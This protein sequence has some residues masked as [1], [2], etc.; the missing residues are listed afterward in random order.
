MLHPQVVT[1]PRRLA[2]T[3][4]VH[5]SGDAWN[6][7]PTRVTE[8]QRNCPRSYPRR[9]QRGGTLTR[10]ISDPGRS[11]P[12]ES[13]VGPSDLTSSYPC[14]L[15]ARELLELTGPR[16]ALPQVLL[17]VPTHG[18]G[19]RRRHWTWTHDGPL[20]GC[21]QPRKCGRHPVGVRPVFQVHGRWHVVG[22]A[23]GAIQSPLA[24]LME[25]THTDLRIP[26]DGRPRRGSARLSTRQVGKCTSE[27]RTRSGRWTVQRKR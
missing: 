13:F 1:R 22:G 16:I 6:R 5:A 26:C 24:W 12:G 11:K 21:S 17:P 3:A 23:Y 15:E 10:S 14:F 7:P 8:T 9:L 2:R 18:R 19:R 4:R 25:E 27:V 20:R